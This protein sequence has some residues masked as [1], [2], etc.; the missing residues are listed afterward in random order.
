[1]GKVDLGYFSL[2]FWFEIDSLFL[3]VRAEIINGLMSKG[4]VQLLEDKDGF[5]YK[6]ISA[7]KA[8]KYVHFPLDQ[9]GH[10]S[11]FSGSKA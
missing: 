4:Q 10:I 7:E 9:I 11:I 2:K 5:I 3:S 1:M 6:Y 8:L